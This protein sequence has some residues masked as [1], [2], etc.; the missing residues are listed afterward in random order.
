MADATFTRRMVP[1]LGRPV[2]RL[3]LAC[4]YGIDA[5]GFERALERGMD[6]VFW[7]SRRTGHLR[8]SLRK[9]LRERRERLSVA[10]GPSV[11][12]FAGNVR[13]G[14]ERLLRS[15]GTDYIDAL[16]LFWLGVGSAWTP[17]TIDELA[18]LKAEGK[19]RA[20][21]ISIHDRERAGR[22]L[23]D[24]P[25]DL[26]MI[27]YNAAHPGAERDIFPHRPGATEQKGRSSPAIVAYTATSWR[28]LLKAPRGWNGPVMTAGDCYRFCLSSPHVDLTL[29]GPRTWAQ[30]QEAL[31]ALD[32][33]PLSAG[34]DRWMREFGHA[35]HG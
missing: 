12:F 21:A 35:V 2:F 4:N 6:Y 5:P 20:I 14:T 22:L 7:T 1:A 28:K 10:T 16:H 24:S 3:G 30:L 8:E 25:I 15:L 13:R 19:I 31:D 32:K 27:R 29:A 23:A 11:G 33:G 26:F 18:K 34:E 9:A 17:R